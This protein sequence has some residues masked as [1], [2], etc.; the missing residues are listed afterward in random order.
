MRV[1]PRRGLWR[2]NIANGPTCHVPDGREWRESWRLLHVVE[3][4]TPARRMYGRSSRSWASDSAPF[5]SYKSTLVAVL[6]EADLR[7]KILQPPVEDGDSA[8]WWSLRC[9]M[10][11]AQRLQ[12]E[13]DSIGF[14]WPF[15]GLSRV[16]DAGIEPAT[17]AV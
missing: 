2:N 3:K 4:S 6:H 14:F 15:A 9:C 17:S 8:S 7:R 5:N 12:Y 11:A 13:D 16:G 1:V 10:V